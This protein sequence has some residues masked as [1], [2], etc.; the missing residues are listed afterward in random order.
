MSKRRGER[1]PARERHWREILG[2]QQKSGLTIQ[3]F[4][5]REGLAASAF[6]HWRRE[7]GLRDRGAQPLTQATIEKSRSPSFAEV[8]IADTSASTEAGLLEVC[9]GESVRIRVPAGFCI[10]TLRAVFTLV[11]LR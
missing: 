9:L 3:E 4:C 8:V 7:I 6:Y 1:D 11:E 2:R 10:E 5:R